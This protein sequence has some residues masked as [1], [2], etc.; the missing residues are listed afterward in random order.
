MARVKFANLG[1][2][3][4]FISSLLGSLAALI[5]F[6]G[7][8]FGLLV[9]VL[10]IA[11][12]M[13]E[14]KA[15]VESGSYLVLDLSVNITDAPPMID[16]GVFTRGKVEVLQLRTATEGLRAAAHDNRI[17][18]LFIV[19]S[20]QSEGL[21]TGYAALGEV[22]QALLDFKQTGKPIHAFLTHAS[23][24]DYFL[25]SVADDVA[26]DPYGALMMPGLAS[27]PVFFANAFKKYG[28]GVQVTRVGKYKS[29][30]EPFIRDDLSP[31]NRLQTQKLLNDVWGDL[32]KD[33]GESRGVTVSE[34]QQVVDREGMIRPEQAEKA[35][36]VD[37][38]IYRDEILD[39]LKKATGRDGSTDAFKQIA[40][41]DYAKLVTPHG[42]RSGGRIA[43]VYAEGDIVDGEGEW[44]QIG[45][46][47]F[48]RELRK[49][50]QD[51]KI[52]AVVLRV[53]S[54]GGSASAS[55]TIQREVRLLKAEKPV[56][57][58]MGSYAASGGYWIST[59]CNR[60]YAEPT[61][62]TGSIGVFGVMFDIQKLAN[63]IGVT[64]DQVKTGVFAD[65]MTISRPKT[66]AELEMVQRSV[67]WIYDQFVGKV[68]ESRNLARPQVEEIAQG[69][70]WSGQEA[71]KLGLVDELGGLDQ[72]IS[73]AA[74][75]AGLGTKYRLVEYPRKKEL[76]EA[77]A[78]M[79]ENIVPSGV[80][81]GMYDRMF[82]RFEHE[83]TTLRSYNDPQGLYARMPVMLTPR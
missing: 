10:I 22:R 55:E 25:A 11:G 82:A 64:F 60:I 8:G 1:R 15:A 47:R 56:V 27:E 39:E 44:G 66:D 30:V 7:A 41:R 43:V 17:K 54:P 5:V 63:G 12:S 70:V 35:G 38:I 76:G 19:G 46:D 58:S 37:R 6:C 72:A 26:L 61:T 18:G 34:I 57:V 74:K 45:G 65:T 31:E 16:F 50:R 14:K 52:K 3:R 67:D 28:I 79:L 51:D 75:L 24:K 40:M 32:L 48:S 59:Y 33:I 83:L 69:R 53:N 23:T 68:A 21:G 77:I 2:M 49:L 71:L 4:N 62:I 29:A 42:S 13:G 9:L 20:V 73:H 78:E 36:L 80:K 81:T